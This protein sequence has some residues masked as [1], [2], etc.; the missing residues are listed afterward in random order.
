MS[1]VFVARDATLRRDVVVKVLPPDLV[2]GVNVERF[3]REILVAAG[4]QHPHI[5]PVLSSGETDGLPWFTMPFVQGE[6]LRDRLARGPL[7]I[8]ESVSILREVAKALVYAHERGVVHRDI[9]PDNVLITGGTA[10][11][12]DFGIAKALSASR[13]G[14]SATATRGSFTQIGMSIG[15][16]VYMA[17]EQAAADPNADARADLYSFGCMAYELLAGRPPFAGMTPQ[18]LLAAHM[19]DRPQSISQLRP[20]T[21]PLLAD[22]VMQ[23]L[24]K[25]PTKRPQSAADV[26]RVLELATTTS[27]SAAAASA[28]LLGGRVRLPVALG[29]WA[30]AFGAAWLLAKAAIITI[31]LPSW[32]LPGA[33]LVAALGLPAILF[34]A[35]VQRQAHHALTRTPTLTPGGTHAHGTMATIA[36]RASPHVTWKRTVRGGFMAFGAFAGLIAIVMALRAFGIGPAASL[37]ASGRITAREPI[38]MTDFAVRGAD[39]SLGGIVTEALRSSLGQTNT[40]TLVP[41]ASVA[42]AL[43]RMQR[44][45]TSRIDLALARDIAAREGIKGV[46]DGEIAQIGSGFVVSVRLVT[47]DSARTLATVQKAVDGPKELIAAVDVIGRDLRGKLGESLKSVQ[48]APP[49]DQVTTASI[50]A[51][52]AYSDGVRAYD[53]A[54]DYPNAI[55]KLSEAVA[56]DSGFAMAWRKLGAVYNAAQYGPAITDSVLAKAFQFRERLSPRERLLTEGSYYYIG[57]GRNR[58]RAIAAS[59]QLLALGDS[60][61]G[62]VNLGLMFESRRQYMRADSL[63]AAAMRISSGS[64]TAA[65]DRAMNF[66]DLGQPVQGISVIEDWGKRNPSPS[67]RAVVAYT[68]GSLFTTMGDYPRAERTLDSLVHGEVASLNTATYSILWAITAAQGRLSETRA[69]LASLSASIPAGQRRAPLVDSL[70]LS[71]VDVTAAEQPERA[72]RRLEATLAATPLSKI[73]IADRD[74]FSVASVYARAGHADRAKAVLAQRDAEVRDTVRLR[75][76][77]PLAHRA[78]GEIA[79]AERRPQDALREFWK[80]DSLPD[81][82]VD[83]CDAC[84]FANIARAY[85]KANVADSAIVY[86]EK[87]FASNTDYRPIV[88]FST[89]GPGLRRLGELYEAKGDR[90]KAAH[91]YQ[92]F[93]NLWKNADPEFQPQVAEIRKRLARMDKSS[94]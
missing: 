59:Q 46:V 11:V 34:T 70:A 2:A 15:T 76:E 41:P 61:Y 56:I 6:S 78:L 8:G 40:V 58:E 57:P 4:L 1:R 64:Q 24:E 28:V 52:R 5:V 51:L 68:R 88:D 23:C 49:L 86:F 42:A 84:T 94:G 77:S 69:R 67:S 29:G 18:R 33:L 39:S 9:K 65:I 25:D 74:Y 66:A 13:T 10:V 20:D 14:E 32:V 38:I 79:I 89:R 27:G 45:A 12:T 48:N 80:G 16:P 71:L 82:P 36:M 54:A 44:P 31:G 17:P 92:E 73:P 19:G 85:D 62:L 90:A 75:A 53:L 22:L 91:Y 72:V 63:F 7:P 50:D 81:G 43:T 87:F 60:L 55:A 30:V 26:V 93:V 37:L 83:E 35:F 47:A 21:P 3:R